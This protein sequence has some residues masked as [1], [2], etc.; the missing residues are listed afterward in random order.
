MK[1]S[2][3]HRPG[4]S[5]GEALARESKE[6]VS[7]LPIGDFLVQGYLAQ[8]AFPEAAKPMVE[9]IKGEEERVS[10]SRRYRAFIQDPARKPAGTEI[11]TRDTAAMQALLEGIQKHP[12]EQTV[13]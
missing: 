8:L 10:L 3:E 2:S 1:Q 4:V 5:T 9:W 13:H 12:P 7:V 6:R 11:D